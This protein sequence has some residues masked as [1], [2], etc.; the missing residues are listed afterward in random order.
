MKRKLTM[1]SIQ[2]KSERKVV[3]L[4]L[5][6]DKN[7]KAL[8]SEEEFNKLTRIYPRGATITVG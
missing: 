3:F 7:G 1:V 5:P 8:L 2:F 6:Y 4:L